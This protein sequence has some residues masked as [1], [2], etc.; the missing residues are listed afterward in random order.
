MLDITSKY[1]SIFKNKP[2]ASWVE[3]ITRDFLT[4]YSCWNHSSMYVKL[5]HFDKYFVKNTRIRGPT[6]K[7][8]QDFSIKYLPFSN[9]QKGQKKPPLSPLSPN[10]PEYALT[11]ILGNAW[12]KCSMPG[13]WICMIILHVR[14]AFEN[15]LGS[16]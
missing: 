11:A 10:I 7:H 13:L 8:F 14:Q 3:H 15:A 16:R 2:P 9:V 4:C 12:I 5:G 1:F 6:G